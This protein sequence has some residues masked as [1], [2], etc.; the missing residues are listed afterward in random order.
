VPVPAPRVEM[1]AQARHYS[2]VVPGTGTMLAGPGRAWVELFRVLLGLT[3]RVSAK[4]PSI[5]LRYPTAAFE[6]LCNSLE[7]RR[8]FSYAVP[9]LGACK[10][11][12]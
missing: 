9:I 1:A 12:C 8:G 2:H 4:W 5:V 11:I 6:H 3:H 10:R 7:L